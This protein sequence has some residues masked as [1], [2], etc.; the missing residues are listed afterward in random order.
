M[1]VAAKEHHLLLFPWPHPSYNS[2]HR[3]QRPHRHRHCY[4]ISFL[5]YFFSAVFLR[6]LYC[7]LYSFACVAC[8][9]RGSSERV[10][11]CRA[12]LQ[13]YGRSA[14]RR[15]LSRTRKVAAFVVRPT[16]KTCQIS[17]SSA[18]EKDIRQ[19]LCW[20]WVSGQRHQHGVLEELSTVS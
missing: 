11:L 3:H 7:C 1:R 2:H 19:I 14:K 5:G 4:L 6:L 17:F 16:N 12:K 13:V 20:K 18:D 8:R 9:K 15:F 10:Q